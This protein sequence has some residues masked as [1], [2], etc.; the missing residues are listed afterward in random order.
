MEQLTSSSS[1]LVQTR[2]MNL[3]RNIKISDEQ[4]ARQIAEYFVSH[5]TAGTGSTYMVYDRQMIVS[6]SWVIDHNLNRYPQITLIDD[7]GY[8]IEADV[9]Y[10]NLNQVTI[11]FAEPTS[12]KAVLI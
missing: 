10:N 6:A 9:F 4:I 3:F 1:N 5:P 2:L 7:E 12:G 11:V 8:E